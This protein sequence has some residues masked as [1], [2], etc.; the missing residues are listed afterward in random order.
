METTNTYTGLDNV[1][2]HVIEQ[3]VVLTLD[4]V[5]MFKQYGKISP[6]LKLNY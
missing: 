3:D 5:F 1:L 6:L 4:I 2:M